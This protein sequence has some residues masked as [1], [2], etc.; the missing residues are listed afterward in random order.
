[1]AENKPG[2][3]LKPVALVVGRDLFD[4]LRQLD[5]VGA[6]Q[7][8]V[9]SLLSSYGLTKEL[10][11]LKPAPL[12]REHLARFHSNQYLEF[13]SKA[14][15]G[16]EEEIEEFGLSFDCPPLS[17]NMLP[18]ASLVGGGSVSAASSLVRGQCKVSIN[19]AGG[20]HHAHRDKAAGFC[21]VNDIVLAI[22]TLQRAFKRI[23]YIDLDC[24]HGDGVE[25]AFSSTD[26]VLTFSI[27]KYEPGYFPGT[28]SLT[29]SG[30]GLGRGYSFNLPLQEGVTDSMYL[31]AF[32]QLFQP[33]F[34]KY[35]PQCIVVQCGADCLMG[36]PMGGFNLTTESIKNCI[37][38]V[39]TT[40][41]PLLLLG[42][43]G[44]V[45]ANA[46][47]LWTVLTSTSLQKY[48][49]HY[50]DP[51]IPD[52]D[53]FFSK[54]GPDFQLTLSPGCCRNKNDPVKVNEMTD[55]LKERIGNL[56]LMN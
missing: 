44:Y 55:H 40:N 36:D 48:N 53:P 10:L 21:Y 34:S 38:E 29:D 18:W 49:P 20:W 1:M 5:K 30:S 26:K 7:Y 17:S 4:C 13:L 37:E 43:G 54:Y 24:H 51:D 12:P 14:E 27:H 22:H 15:E 39:L 52:E 23:L 47:R 6:R 8:L 42:G 9:H 32:T 56:K 3:I 46:A 2:S 33:M 41:V 19:W 16:S 28:G 31:Q 11:L 45:P 35:Q 25:E 50:L